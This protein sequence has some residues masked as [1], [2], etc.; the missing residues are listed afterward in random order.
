M[1][2]PARV[3]LYIL[4]DEEWIEA[5]MGFLTIQNSNIITV[6]ANEATTLFDIPIEQ[7][8][9]WEKQNETLIVWKEKIWNQHQALSFLNED[10]CNAY[11]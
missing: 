7:T 9:Q 2:E 11:L 4:S 3:K 10:E 1:L 8:E 6:K 5:G